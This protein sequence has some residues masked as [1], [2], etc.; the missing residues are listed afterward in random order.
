MTEK[1]FIEYAQ[2]LYE[3]NISLK[4]QNDELFESRLKYISKS[5]ELQQRIEKTIEYIKETLELKEEYPEEVECVVNDLLEIL[6]GEN[7]E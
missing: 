7:N 5:C 4:K 3:N 6:K 2:E 1:K